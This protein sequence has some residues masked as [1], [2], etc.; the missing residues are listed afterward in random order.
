MSTN[1]GSLPGHAI[2]YVEVD[3]NGGIEEVVTRWLSS[4][5]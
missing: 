4:N 1:P 3:R 5:G 2:V